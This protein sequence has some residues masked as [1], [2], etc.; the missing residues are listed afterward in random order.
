MA[1]V[2]GRTMVLV[3]ALAL[4]GCAAWST[5]DV[6]APSMAPST[7]VAP[8]SAPTLRA[9]TTVDK[10]ALFEGD[11]FDRAYETIGDISV[12]VNKTTIFHHDPTRELVARR[13]KEEAAKLGAD[14]VILVRYGTVGIGFMSWGSLDGKGRAIIYK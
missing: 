8:A 2:V 3:A 5:A 6:Q 7:A 14:A 12:T 10:V 4:G 9:P 1:L 11:V 13:L